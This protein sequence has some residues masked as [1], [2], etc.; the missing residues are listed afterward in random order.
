MKRNKR[1][2]SLVTLVI[3][4][5]IMI[6]LAG[7]IIVSLSNSNIFDRASEAV[8][9]YNL[10]QVQSLASLKWLDAYYDK[11][12]N[13]EKEYEDLPISLT[14]AKVIYGNKIKSKPVPLK[15][16]SIEDG[17]VTVWGKVFS[18]DMRD[19]RDGK[20]KIIN[21]N[22]TDKTSSYTV[23]IFEAVQNCEQLVAN[24]SDG[25][26]VMLRGHV[27][28]DDYIKTYCIKAN[29]VTVSNNRCCSRRNKTIA[30][31]KS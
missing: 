21:F 22:I 6:I 10:K 27:E 4:I 20:R 8:D 19:T 30:I 1:G 17:N 25:K 11:D 16:I 14:N 23:K 7:V 12:I 2:I 15:G 18:L 24:I 13:T 26:V 5:I 31:V 29:S 28:Y 3:T 9:E